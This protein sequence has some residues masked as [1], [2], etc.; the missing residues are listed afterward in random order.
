MK[1][2]P[3]DSEI[4]Y[5]Y[6]LYYFL[7]F[8]AFFTLLSIILGWRFGLIVGLIIFILGF[9]TSY[10][11]MTLKKSF[12]PPDKKLTAQRMAKEITKDLN[13]LAISRFASQLY[14]YFNEP[15]QAISLLRKYQY[16]NDSILC[17]TLADFFLREGLPHQGLKVIHQNPQ[18]N[19]DPL[20][21]MVLGRTYQQLE[22][23]EK[24]IIYYRKSLLIA[25]K[26]GYPHNGANKLTKTFLALSYR[27]ST[28][29]SLGDCYSL[30]K[31]H[32]LAKKHYILG[33][34]LFFDLS[35]WKNHKISNPYSPHSYTKSL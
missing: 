4:L 16:T 1:E 32:S 9:L 24:A 7:S 28:Y 11:M 20:L 31:N 6:K 21:L 34:L 25:R 17:A 3:F 14:F 33:N 29:H 26:K 18:K 8:L 15:E 23:L 12:S 22:K 35:L 30:L 5:V 2:V 10:L 13:P 19:S 27:A